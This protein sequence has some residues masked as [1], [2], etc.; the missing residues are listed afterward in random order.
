MRQAEFSF[1]AFDVEVTLWKGDGYIFVPEFAI[2]SI[3]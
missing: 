3:P 1:A 2:D